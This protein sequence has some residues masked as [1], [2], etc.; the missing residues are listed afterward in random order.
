M[1]RVSLLGASGSVGDSCLKV[2]ER[3]R[4]KISLQNC[5]IHSNLTK[6]MEIIEKFSPVTLVVTDPNVDKSILGT[7][8]KSTKILYGFD[9]LNEIVT[10]SEVDIVITA[11]VG[12][13]GINPTVAAIHAGKKI[14]IANKETLVTFGP[15]IK[16]LLQTSK[17]KLIPVDSEHNALFQLLENKNKDSIRSITLTASGGSF[18]DYPIEAL[19]NVTVEQALKHPTWNM[20][21]K[22]TIDSASLVNKSLEVIEAHYLFDFSY[23]QI[24]IVIHPESIVH[25]IV[26]NLD[27]SV[28]MYASYPSM[29]FP[30]AHSIFYPSPIPEVLIEK[31]PYTYEKLNFREVDVKRYPALPLA[32]QCGRKGGTAPC[33]FNAA[34]EVAVD[35]FL[36]E[37]IAFTEIPEIIEKTLNKIQI[38][39][40]TSLEEYL[41]IDSLARKLAWNRKD[42]I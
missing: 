2:I 40:P 10:E 14:G 20:G 42:D 35:L 5:S 12:S 3:F 11:I 7:H 37:K 25:G 31:K 39:H 33:I 29:M 16:K 17:S 36:K 24:E 15:Y 18:R 27:G 28:L 30:V 22:I 41:E 21:A 4:E 34:N 38:S 13:V 6:G 1:I 8:K 26:E 19:K 32:L 23:D 9:S